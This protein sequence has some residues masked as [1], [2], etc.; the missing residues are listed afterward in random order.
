MNNYYI[1]QIKQFVYIFGISS[2]GKFNLLLNIKL[3]IY[4]IT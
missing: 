4:K 3:R 2:Y 1:N